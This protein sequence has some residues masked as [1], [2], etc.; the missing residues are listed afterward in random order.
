MT[1]ETA[2]PIL[3]RLNYLLKRRDLLRL[4][5]ASRK[6]LGSTLT[7]RNTFSMSFKET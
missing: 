4:R 6:S 1:Q 2:M 7:F 3:D 5:K